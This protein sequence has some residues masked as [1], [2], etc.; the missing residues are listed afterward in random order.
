M[1]I[2][3]KYMADTG[4]YQLTNVGYIVLVAT[5][6]LVFLLGFFLFRQRST[7]KADTK[8]LVFSSMAIAIAMVTSLIRL[9]RM[10]MG[11]SVTLFSM[12]FICLV[13]YMY[14]LGAGITA[15]ISYGFLQLIVDPYI[16]SVPQMFIDY[17]LAYGSLGFSGVFCKRKHGLYKGYILGFC[18]RYFFAFLS[19]LIFFGS[20][21]ADY[22][23]SAPVYSLLYNGAYL[24]A[25]AVLTL[26][27]LALPPVISAI[28]YI[29]QAAL[30][31]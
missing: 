18:C 4:S 2:F 15:G 3:A 24:G 5:M 1:S 16:I 12:F 14:G 27:V 30:A 22:N 29:K 13:G 26:V 21:A 9:F 28:S 17:I 11:G 19:G 20:Y 7:K 25:E 6:L 10:P 23:M 8:Q 31:Q